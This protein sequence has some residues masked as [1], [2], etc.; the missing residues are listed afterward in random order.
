MEGTLLYLSVK[1]R[2]NSNKDIILSK[3]VRKEWSSRR[4]FTKSER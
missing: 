3:G 2:S 4:Y 1:D